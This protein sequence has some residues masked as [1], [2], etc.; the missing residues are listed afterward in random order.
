MFDVLINFITKGLIDYLIDITAYQDVY[1]LLL[2][3]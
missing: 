3:H 2:V 1:Y